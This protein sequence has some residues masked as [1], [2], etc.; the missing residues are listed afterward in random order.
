M[1]ALREIFPEYAEM[2]YVF[3]GSL[4]TRLLWKKSEKPTPEKKKGF[5]VHFSKGVVVTPIT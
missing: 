5:H 3:T 4:M 1:H 2:K